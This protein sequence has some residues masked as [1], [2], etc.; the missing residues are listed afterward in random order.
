MRY[1][2]SVCV[3]SA[4]ANG[5][6]T[7]WW[8][9]RAVRDTLRNRMYCG[10]M[11]Q[12]RSRVEGGVQIKLPESEW[13]ITENTHEAIVSREVFAEVQ[14][15]W[16]KPKVDKEAYYKGENTVDIFR[17]KLYCGVCGTLILRKRTGHSNYS[18][19]CPKGIHYT[20]KACDGMRTTQRIVKDTVF[21]HIHKNGLSILIKPEAKADSIFDSDRY[22]GELVKVKSDT[23][24]NSRYLIG[25]YESLKLGD[26]TETEFRELKSTYELRMAS[27]AEQETNLQDLIKSSIRKEKALVIARNSTMSVR[28]V[29]DLTADVI[30]QTV[31]KIIIH[32]RDNLEI[33]NRNFGEDTAFK[34]EA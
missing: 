31:E 14:K 21:E 11:I 13:T 23:D 32:G 6:K 34:K 4:N 10:D 16:D 30:E 3:A 9:L 27:L 8:S 7:E 18:Y 12:G 20:K 17:G 1:L 28:T 24:K 26:I 19:F 2:H 33:I 29:A 25:L 15:F 22:K 5:A